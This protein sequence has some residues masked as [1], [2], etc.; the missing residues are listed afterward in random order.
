MPL[1][2]VDGQ[3]SLSHGYWKIPVPPEHRHLVHGETSALE[4]RLVMACHLDR[5]LRADESV[6][7]RNGDRLDNRIQNL[8]LWSRYQPTG[9]RT[10]DLLTWALEVIRRYD[11]WA[12]DALGLDL[13]PTTGA[14]DE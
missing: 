14:R 11:P 10:E 3:G 9:A 4:H 13:D 12:V 2:E 1:R 7:H 8:E 5:S 6:H